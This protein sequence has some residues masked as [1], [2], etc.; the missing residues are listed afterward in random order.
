MLTQPALGGA[1]GGYSLF[2]GAAAPP[3][4]QP[5]VGSPNL[6]GAA[7]PPPLP[8]A[9]PS[10]VASP[11]LHDGTSSLDTTPTIGDRATLF[12]TPSPDPA[13][14]FDGDT[15]LMPY[16]D[17]VAARI[18]ASAWRGRRSHGALPL[19]S[20]DCLNSKRHNKFFNES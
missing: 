8:R 5:Y 11:N 6:P 9:P 14:M 3:P 20:L 12:A 19:P 16:V 15:K 1:A 13:S 10:H 7:P 18:R 2:S 17:W 4:P